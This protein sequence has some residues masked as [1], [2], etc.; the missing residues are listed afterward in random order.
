ML[1]TGI[2]FCCTGPFWS[3]SLCFVWLVC[4]SPECLTSALTQ[5][6]GGGLLFRFAGSVALRGGRGPADRCRWRVWGALAVFRPHWVRP[7]SRRVLSLSALLRLPAALCVTGP[8][9]RAVPVFGHSTKAQPRLGQ[10]FV[11]SPPKQLRQPG[12]W[13]AQS[14]REQCVLSPPRSQPQF[15]ARWSGAPSICSGELAFS[16]D[17]PGACQPYRI[18]WSLW[19]ETV[20]LFAVW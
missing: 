20:S 15:P 6:G 7:R 9:L 8:E 10:H 4:W 3:G 5:A 11:P 16:R 17:P 14:T 18:S 12:A 2:W 1:P 13:R 19:L